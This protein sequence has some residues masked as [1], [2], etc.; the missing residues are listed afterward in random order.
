MTTHHA[1]RIIDRRVGR[2]ALWFGLLGGAV[3]WL[4]HFL[5]AYAISEFGCVAEWGDRLWMGISVAAWLL[6]AMT[7]ATTALAA[8]A[9]LT[10]H[11]VRR[12]IGGSVE[13]LPDS[14]GIVA[15]APYMAYIGWV[16]SVLS[17]V[18]ILVQSVPILY[19]LEDC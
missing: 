19:W 9:L 12:R 18:I 13:D 15:S 1:T 6:I 5:A 16:L 8:A 14:E 10:A 17:L 4:I 7:A 11:W 2:F 3:A